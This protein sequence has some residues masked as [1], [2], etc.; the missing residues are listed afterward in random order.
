MK[1]FL[2]AVILFSISCTDPA[3]TGQAENGTSFEA[4]YEKLSSGERQAIAEAKKTLPEHAKYVDQR[5]KFNV[6]KA[7][8]ALWDTGSYESPSQAVTRANEMELEW[9]QEIGTR[10]DEIA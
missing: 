3:E 4:R 5:G 2:L 8:K 7:A 6:R 9:L 1:L 10:M